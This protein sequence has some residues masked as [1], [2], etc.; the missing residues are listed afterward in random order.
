MYN[1]PVPEELSDCFLAKYNKNKNMSCIFINYHV[2]LKTKKIKRYYEQRCSK[3][4]LGHFFM[5]RTAYEKLYG[6]F[7]ERE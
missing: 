6:E 1:M 4:F 3:V 2:S 5:H 7:Q